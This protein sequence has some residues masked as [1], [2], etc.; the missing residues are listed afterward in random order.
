MK[1]PSDDPRFVYVLRC[2]DG[3]LD[4]GR[5]RNQIRLARGS[6]GSEFGLEA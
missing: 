1:K 5:S 6:A 2:A 3:S 4:T